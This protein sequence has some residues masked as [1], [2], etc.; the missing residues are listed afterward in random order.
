[1]YE[2][3]W[4]WLSTLMDGRVLEED[5][6]FYN[7]FEAIQSCLLHRQKYNKVASDNYLFVIH[8]PV[9]NK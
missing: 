1:M 2:D 3:S 4:N 5:K 6:E 9:T 8:D 7:P